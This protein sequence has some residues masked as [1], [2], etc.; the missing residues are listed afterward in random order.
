[1]TVTL[2]HGVVNVSTPDR[3]E[4]TQRHQNDDRQVGADCQNGSRGE[5]SAILAG[6]FTASRA[7]A[8]LRL[9]ST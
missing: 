7:Y 1:M 6:A 2:C 8:F 5:K 9:S 3:A 4:M